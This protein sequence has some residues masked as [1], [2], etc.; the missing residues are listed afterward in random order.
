[1]ITSHIC[2]EGAGKLALWCL[3][4][5]AS[6]KYY[7]CSL[8]RILL[9]EA[10]P[11]QSIHCLGMSMQHMNL[12]AAQPSSQSEFLFYLFNKE[13]KLKLFLEIVLSP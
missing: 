9:S 3:Y 5:S 8:L 12:T 11:P 13:I 2:T 1:M 10:L 7:H 4:I 6:C